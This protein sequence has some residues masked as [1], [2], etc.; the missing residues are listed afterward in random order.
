ML[1]IMTVVWLLRLIWDIRCLRLCG[2]VFGL[3]GLLQVNGVARRYAVQV[4][5]ARNGSLSNNVLHLSNQLTIAFHGFPPI[6][7]WVGSDVRPDSMAAPLYAEQRIFPFPTI[8]II[9]DSHHG[10]EALG[11]AAL[12]A[13]ALGAYEHHQHQQQQ[14]APP[15]PPPEHHGHGAEIAVGVAA[16]TALGGYELYQHHQHQQ[17]QQPP[18]PPPPPPQ[19]HHGAEALAGGA[20][21][22]AGYE[23]YEHHE[24]HQQQQ[25][26]MPAPPPP[27]PT[28]HVAEA[29]GAGIAGGA[30][31]GGY[32]IYQHHE[33]HQQQ[34]MHQQQMPQPP[35]PGSQHHGA[36]ALAAGAV[37]I[38]AAEAIHLH[39]QQNQPQPQ[40]P[41][42]PLPPVVQEGPVQIPEAPILLGAGEFFEVSAEGAQVPVI[43]NPAPPPPITGPPPP[44]TGPPVGG[45]PMGGPGPGYAPRMDMGIAAAS[46]FGATAAEQRAMAAEQRA[47]STNNLPSQ[48]PPQP[49]PQSQPTPAMPEPPVFVEQIA[50]PEPVRVSPVLVETLPAP[51]PPAPQLQS[52]PLPLPPPPDPFQNIPQNPPQNPPPQP[53][54]LSQP[55]P[56]G[57]G[58][59]QLPGGWTS[60]SGQRNQNGNQ[61]GNQQRPP[62]PP[63]A[64]PIQPLPPIQ[65]NGSQPTNG[66]AT[67]PQGDERTDPELWHFFPFG[68]AAQMV[69]SGI[70]AIYNR[71]PGGQQQSSQV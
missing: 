30:A 61:N 15:P 19:H 21:A 56:A 58:R 46:A 48:L 65:A 50:P 9:A 54:V 40:I 12:G 18:A 20:A 44:F 42:L 29:V 41:V 25:Q 3:L 28:H 8:L 63:V 38:G 6:M 14:V 49:P 51:P 45:P 13:A 24:Q 11:V 27:P 53:P 68:P 37:G 71:A 57:I 32:E 26:Q 69:L 33:Q 35:P 22:V 62:A 66:T 67:P 34:Q 36:E 43:V 5:I 64:A 10:A 16:A 59:S 60:P 23:L 7:P 2:L 17:Q 4:V 31:L 52:Q 70:D 55:L 1:S 47:V 39:N